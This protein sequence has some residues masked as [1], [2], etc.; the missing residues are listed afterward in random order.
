VHSSALFGS[1]CDWTELFRDSES[2]LLTKIAMDKINPMAIIKKLFVCL[3]DIFVFFKKVYTTKKA[4]TKVS[5][6]SVN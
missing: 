5:A 2:Q 3:C 6:I 1:L 4:P